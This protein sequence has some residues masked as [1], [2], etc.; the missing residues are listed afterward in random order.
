MNE[1]EEILAM[2]TDEKNHVHWSEVIEEV[3]LT[4]GISEEEARGLV[5]D[6]RARRV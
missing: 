6:W 5:N 4:F 3:I 1:M 2:C